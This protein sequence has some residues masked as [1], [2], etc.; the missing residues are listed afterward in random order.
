MCSQGEQPQIKQSFHLKVN[1]YSPDIF[2][3]ITALLAN[4]ILHL[5]VQQ[6]SCLFLK[7]KQRLPFLN[8]SKFFLV[9]W[10]IY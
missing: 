3:H 7:K 10:Q 2:P 6:T 8:L 1:C 4:Q 5:S 9:S